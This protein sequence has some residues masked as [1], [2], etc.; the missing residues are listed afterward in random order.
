MWDRQAAPQVARRP[1]ARAWPWC[2]GWWWPCWPCSSSLLLTPSAAS[3]RSVNH[4]IIFGQCWTY[5]SGLRLFKEVC[6]TLKNY[7]CWVKHSLKRISSKQRQLVSSHF[8]QKRNSK[9]KIFLADTS[10]WSQ[11]VQRSQWST[12]TGLHLLKQ[13]IPSRENHPN[14]CH[15]NMGKFQK[16][17]SR[18]LSIKGGGVT[19]FPLRKNPLKIGRTTVFLGRRT[20]FC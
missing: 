7:C 18:K 10:R 3:K 19:P 5:K 14:K 12:A 6:E 1:R 15:L 11:N 9:T 17:Q 4:S 8:Y 13:N 2:W 16:T 20:L